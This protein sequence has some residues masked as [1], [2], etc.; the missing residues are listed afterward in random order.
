MRIKTSI[1]YSPNF[2]TSARNKKNIKYIVYHY[3]GMRSENKAIKRL[4]DLNSNVSCHYFIKRNGQ[5]ILMVPELYEAWHAGKS[6]WKKDISLNKKSLGIEISNK[7]HE[8]G[9]ENFSKNQLTSL[10]I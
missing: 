9:Y 10:I 6:N 8:F 7:G 5:I 3:T 2:S 1:N 4:T